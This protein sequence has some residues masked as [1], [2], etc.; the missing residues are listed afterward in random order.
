MSKC[1]KKCNE[2]KKRIDGI[3]GL[4]DKFVYKMLCNIENEIDLI[5]MYADLDEKNAT[6]F[7][8]CY[9]MTDEELCEELLKHIPYID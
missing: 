1:S 7:K 2:L 9:V 8:R 6:C 3:S 4:D 5:E